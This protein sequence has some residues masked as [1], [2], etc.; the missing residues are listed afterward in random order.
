MCIYRNGYDNDADFVADLAKQAT[1]TEEKLAQLKS[2]GAEPGR[3]ASWTQFALEDRAIV[4]LMQNA[5]ASG[6]DLTD[7]DVTDA[8][9]SSVFEKSP[10]ALQA[11]LTPTLVPETVAA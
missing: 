2:E 5:S 3:I 4:T 6:K 1:A 9:Y 8:I 10:E 11:L 7:T